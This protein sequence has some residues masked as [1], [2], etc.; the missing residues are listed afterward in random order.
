MMYHSPKHRPVPKM[1]NL[2][3]I[4]FWQSAKWVQYTC[5]VSDVWPLWSCVVLS[6]L[7]LTLSQVCTAL[8][9]PHYWAQPGPELAGMWT[10]EREGGQQTD[11][12]LYCTALLHRN[13]RSNNI[14]SRS[15]G[16]SPVQCCQVHCVFWSCLSILY[17]YSIIQNIITLLL[18]AQDKQGI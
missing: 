15:Q 1:A 9:S 10:G 5:Y 8:Q 6:C 18:Y 7:T 11:Q 3:Y 13:S 16:F 2:L 17:M 12:G 14:S 4:I